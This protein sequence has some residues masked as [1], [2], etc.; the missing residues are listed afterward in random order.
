MIRGGTPHFDYVCRG[1]TDGVRGV[2]R[3]TGVPIAFGVLT[4]DD[5]DQALARAGGSAGQQGRRGGA[6]GDRDGAPGARARA[7]PPE[8]LVSGPRTAPRHRSRQAALQVLYA[9][10][11]GA[12]QP[13]S[14]RAH[15]A[16]L[17]SLA[18]HFELPAGARGLRE[19]AR[20]RRRDATATTIDRAHHGGRAT[21]GGSSA[22]PP[23]IATCCGSPPTRSCSRARRASVVIDEAVELARRF[24]DD[25][26]PRFVN[27]VLDALARAA[28]AKAAQ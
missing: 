10:D 9:A 19:G 14:R 18:E 13:R 25:A 5:L 27:G 3:D 17:A 4:T 1:V 8:A 15:E 2:M 23:S 16:S 7:R 6:R 24:G 12:A 28:D 21:T 11:V 26:S 22:W 20:A